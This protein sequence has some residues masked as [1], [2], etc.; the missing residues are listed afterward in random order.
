M[1]IHK[2]IYHR[3]YNFSNP[4]AGRVYDNKP[5]AQNFSQF[6][7]EDIKLSTAGS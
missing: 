6:V 4:L 3:N 5:F 1:F 7:E 2:S